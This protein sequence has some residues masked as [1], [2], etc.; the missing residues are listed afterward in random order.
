MKVSMEQ[1]V[2]QPVN[3]RITRAGWVLVR[4]PVKK[5]IGHLNDGIIVP[6]ADLYC[7]G[8]EGKKILPHHHSSYG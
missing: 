8:Y 5:K 4:T 2:K 6:C 1:H 3:R 7:M